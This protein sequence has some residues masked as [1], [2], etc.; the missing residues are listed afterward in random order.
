M[1]SLRRFALAAILLL[2]TPLLF[3]QSKVETLNLTFTTIDVPGAGETIA[4]G[5]NSAGDMVGWY[6]PTGSKTGNG[7]LLS[8]GNFT[9]LSYPGGYDTEAR[10][11]TDTG[12]I[13]GNAYISSEGAVGFTY[14]A[15]VFNTIQINGY[16]DTFA[17]G[18]NAAGNV[19][20][21][22][23]FGGTQGFE[24]FGTKFRNIG[25]P[26]SYEGILATAVNNFGQ[27]VGW[28]M[29]GA[30]GS[31][32][33]YQHGNYKMINVP[34]STG[35]TEVWGINDSGIVVGTYSG[36]TPSCTYHG[37]ALMKGKYFSFDVPGALETFAWGISPSGQIV[38]SWADSQN[39]HGFVSSPITADH[40][41]AGTLADH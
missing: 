8:G 40:F 29:Q 14:Q 4:S 36:C 26:G 3:A 16:P 24:Q 18:I 28:T 12:L 23:G 21:T 6:V 17:D 19:V 35:L 32:F 9:F 7:F 1:F 27:I 5:I 34:G 15:G 38:G 2:A 41:A 22:Y 37:F 13:V 25:P 10:G 31:G 33:L 20:G 30:A 39:C 11:I